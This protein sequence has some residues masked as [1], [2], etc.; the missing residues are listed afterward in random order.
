MVRKT[1]RV[2]G[3]AR[4]LLNGVEVC[5]PDVEYLAEYE[6]IGLLPN[7]M[8]QIVQLVQADRASPL[9][10]E[11][12]K[13]MDGKPVWVTPAGFWALV[14]SK[15]HDRVKLISNDGEIVYADKEIELVGPVYEY[16]PVPFPLAGEPLTQSDLDKMHFERVCI[17]YGVEDGERSVVEDGVVLYGRLYSIDTL[18]GAGFEELLLDAMSGET[19]DNP[20][21]IYT[22]YRR[23]TNGKEIEGCHD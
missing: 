10:V 17:D 4:M 18:D 8:E 1:W 3:E 12:L 20:T 13:K 11:Q 21:G 19:L 5:G 16:P 15:P 23:P 9:T 6:D 22:V 2:N 14:I 7:E